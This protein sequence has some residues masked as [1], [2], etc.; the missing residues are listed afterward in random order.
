MQTSMFN[1]YLFC[2]I[3]I[4][5]PFFKQIPGQPLATLRYTDSDIEFKINIHFQLFEHMYSEFMCAHYVVVAISVYSVLLEV[6]TYSTWLRRTR[7]FIVN[8]GC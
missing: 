3:I 6:H 5:K 4:V 7:T 1:P 2:V 8:V